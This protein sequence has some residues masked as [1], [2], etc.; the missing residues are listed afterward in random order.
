MS[1]QVKLLRALETGQYRRVGGRTYRKADVR[2]VCATNRHLWESVTAGLFREDL[3][4]RIA[5]LALR[6]PPLRERLEDIGLLAPNL[7]DVISQT[8]SRRFTL[9]DDAIEQLKQYHYPGNVRELRNILLIA[10]AHSSNGE[11]GGPL[12]SEVL[13][14][15]SRKVSEVADAPA[16]TAQQLSAVRPS[17]SM[18]VSAAETLQDVEARHISE[19]LTQHHNNRRKVAELLEISERTLYRKLKRYHLS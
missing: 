6:L 3:Y 13:L 9:T 15:Q 4:Y 11:I 7:L 19:L 16:E 18:P 12:I 2:I 5:C 14:E 8:M 10:A 1:Q 17:R